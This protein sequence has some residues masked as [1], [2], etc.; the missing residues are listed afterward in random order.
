MQAVE[1]LPYNQVWAV[2]FEF[3]APP[4]DRPVPICC[5]AHE[6][7][8]GKVVRLLGEELRRS[9]PPYDVSANSLIV[10]YY[11]SAE[12]GC[13]LALGWAVPLRIL[14]LF[15]E[16]RCMTNGLETPCG[17]GLLG[18]LAAF[19]LPA[20]DAAEKEKM[21]S[22]ALRGGPFTADEERALIEYCES[23]VVSLKKLLLA[24]ISRIDLP[25]ALLRG[26]YMAAAARIEYRGIPIDVEAHEKLLSNWEN[27]KQALVARIDHDFGVFDGV[28]FRADRWADYLAKRGIPWPRLASG[29]LALDDD[30]FREMV[31]AYPELSPVREIRHA[32]SEMRLNDLQVGC[33][34]R[35]RTILSAFRARTSRNQPSNT[36]FVFGPSVWLRGLIRPKPESAVGYIDWAQQEFGIASA[37]SGDVAMLAAYNSGDPYLAFGKQ[38]GRIPRDGTKKTHGPERELFKQCA[39]AV[40]Y[41]MG[42]DSLAAR[43]GEPTIVARDLLRMHR[44]TYPRFW[45]WADG[46]VDFAM[47]HGYLHTVFGWTI[48]RGTNPNPRMLRNFLMQGNGAEM[49]RLA[50]CYATEAGIGVCAPVHDAVLIEA[51]ADTIEDAVASTQAAMAH[52]S[53]DVLAGFELRSDAQIVAY[54]ERYQD[55]RGRTMWEAVW[56][57]INATCNPGASAPV[58]RT[59]PVQQCTRDLR[60]TATDPCASARP[61]PSLSLSSVSPL[62]P[63]PSPSRASDG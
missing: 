39:L 12:I 19:G 21:R 13:H 4:G 58:D 16:F 34:G 57:L 40:Q 10:A 31:K 53:R 45:T 23:D 55:E 38:A 26:R 11:A 18:A 22:L 44:T 56:A 9:G 32:L 59:E 28:S 20:L 50:C 62:G 49:L 41:G 3:S 24:M 14:D 63:T 5:V 35:N 6:L 48:H 37:L 54:P 47:I 17:A 27:I 1:D 7:K 42:E 29:R 30:T 61:V 60:A 36:K 51:A 25:R 52:A 15:T 2:D 33:D 46:A 8:S 43:I